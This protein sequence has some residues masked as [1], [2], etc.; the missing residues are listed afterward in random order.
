[1]EL[2]SPAKESGSDSGSMEL[3]S[4]DPASSEPLKTVS[5]FDATLPEKTAEVG[6]EALALASAS[7]QSLG[8]IF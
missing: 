2:L 1:M 8:A 7:P 6:A 3:R 5:D 4:P